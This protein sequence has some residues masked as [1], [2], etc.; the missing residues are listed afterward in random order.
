MVQNDSHR[1]IAVEEHFVHNALTT[2]FTPTTL[3]QPKPLP[4]QALRLRRHQD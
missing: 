4:R 3:R 2:H 1:V